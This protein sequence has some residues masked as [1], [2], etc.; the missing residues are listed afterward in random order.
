MKITPAQKNKIKAYSWALKPAA[1]LTEG[2]IIR[3][4]N[5]GVGYG[6]LWLSSG[7]AYKLIGFQ[8]IYNNTAYPS[9]AFSSETTI[10]QVVF[11]AGILSDTDVIECTYKTFMSA[12]TD[13]YTINIYLGING[14][15]TDTLIF[16]ITNGG[17]NQSFAQK[18]RFRLINSTTIRVSSLPTTNS[19]GSSAVTTYGL[20]DSTILDKTANNLKLTVTAVKASGSGGSILYWRELII[21][22]IPGT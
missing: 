18:I 5:Y 12:L 3:I 10:G 14:N 9:G 4:I 6:S 2:T 17:A 11:P 16:T 20:T 7:G 15:N 21:N 19:T 8:Q 22:H 13:N 1:F